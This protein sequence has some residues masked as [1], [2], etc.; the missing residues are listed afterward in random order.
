LGGRSARLLGGAAL[1]A[2]LGLASAP[3]LRAEDVEDDPM[4]GFED[5][6]FPSP[7]EPVSEPEPVP[8]GVDRW[9]DLTGDVAITSAF[10]YP[11][12][13]STSGTDYQGLVGLR[14]KLGLQLD[15]ELPR[16]WQARAAGSGFYDFAYL[17]R[18]KG[19]YTNAVLDKYEWDADVGELW[20]EG[21]L[22]PAL[23]LKLGR[24]VVNWGRSDTLRVLDVLNPIDNREP[25]LLD[26]IDLRL[27]VTMAKLSYYPHPRWGITGIYIPEI[28]FSIDPPF[29]SDFFPGPQPLPPQT[30]HSGFTLE[31]P[32]FAAA[33]SGH[34]EGWDISFHFADAYEDIPRFD[35][36]PLVPGGFQLQHSRVL[37]GGVG[38]AYA[39]GAW[40]VKGELAVLDGIDF[41]NTGEKTRIDAMLGVEYYGFAENNIALEVVNRHLDDFHGSMKGFPDFARRD[42]LETALR[43]SADWWNARLHTTAL[44]IVIGAKAQDGSVLRFSADYDIRDALVVGA[45]IQI[46]LKGTDSDG[47]LNPFAPNDR[48]FLRIKYSF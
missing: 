39:F 21:P 37:L 32:Q 18:G 44:A 40:L 16:D 24:Q 6:G 45:G 23:D 2:G 8:S 25:G 17:A 35:P 33:V 41:A 15:L 31:H 4:S 29:G 19:E 10:S 7:G 11:K 9:W 12:H 47:R 36:N 43:W 5:D 46:F 26:L 13:R 28:R 30:T 38:G 27:P 22:L 48:V 20:V 3:A 1:L 42:T 34:F 14:T